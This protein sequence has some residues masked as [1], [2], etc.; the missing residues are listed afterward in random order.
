MFKILPVIILMIAINCPVYAV[1]YTTEQPEV[2][3]V[4]NRTFI[5]D[6]NNL[7]DV[8]FNCRYKDET[9]SERLDRLE[10]R[11]YGAKQSGTDEERLSKLKK[12][13]RLYRSTRV[14]EMEREYS[15]YYYQQPIYSNGRGWRGFMGNLGNYFTGVP[16]GFTP[17]IYNNGFYNNSFY[18]SPDLYD[19]GNSKAYQTN[20]GWGYHNTTGSTRSGITILD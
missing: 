2:I 9:P 17:P 7:E 8:F 5:R 6:L 10:Y 4:A 1:I 12:T 14:T 3:G 15:P 18:N 16:T 19:G 11:A 20:Y 13:A